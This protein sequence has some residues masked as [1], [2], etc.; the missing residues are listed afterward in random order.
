MAMVS[1]LQ[2]FWIVCPIDYVYLKLGAPSIEHSI[3]DSAELSE[4]NRTIT[5]LV[6]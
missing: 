2:H 4:L 3:V 1:I 6:D 5:K